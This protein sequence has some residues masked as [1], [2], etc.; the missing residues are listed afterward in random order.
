MPS[1][2]AVVSRVRGRN[3]SGIPSYVSIPRHHAYAGAHWLGA[4]HHFFA[5]NDD[6]NAETFEVSDLSINSRLDVK[7][8]SD[9][10][11]LLQQLDCRK[12][13]H[14]LAGDAKALDAFSQQAFDLITGKKAQQAFDISQESDSL[15][16]R[17]GRN[18]VGQRMLLARR[19]VEAK[20][21]F[22]TVR[23]G[24]WDDHQQL[25]EKISTR[26]PMI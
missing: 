13:A 8:L 12:Q 14:D 17:Y 24:D 5:V 16:D 21:P 9:R 11:T 1:V 20:V 19:L 4:Q 18:T 15:R 26:A 6:P 3:S 23:M 25:P 10:R 2:G 7:R 22:V